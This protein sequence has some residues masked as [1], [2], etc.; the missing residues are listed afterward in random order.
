MMDKNFGWWLTGFIDGE[1]CFRI[2]K[3]K[4]G[5]YYA[6]HFHIKLRSDDKKILEEC[7]RRT[8]L[9]QLNDVPVYNTSKPGVRWIIQSRDECLALMS[10]IDEFPLKSKKKRDYKIWK[11]ALL[12]WK[13]SKRGNR[14]HGHRDWTPM[15]KLKEELAEVRRWKPS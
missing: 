4:K 2:H 14:W 3:E 1:G 12:W 13:N 15:I 11:K 5:E 7:Q 8:N 6:C 10:I 9:G